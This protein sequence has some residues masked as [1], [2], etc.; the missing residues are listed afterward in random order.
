MG[1]VGVAS[2]ATLAQNIEAYE[3][4]KDEME[5]D[6]MGKWV[7]F[8][9]GDYIDDFDDFQ[10]AAMLAIR[11]WGRGPYLI[12]LVG[13]NEPVIPTAILSGPVHGAG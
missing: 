13:E 3:E 11:K 10:D 4:R 1:H 6:H 5:S 2:V 9:D 8:Y 12:R 7:I